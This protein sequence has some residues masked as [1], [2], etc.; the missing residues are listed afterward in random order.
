MFHYKHS[1]GIFF[2]LVLNSK[3]EVFVLEYLKAFTPLLFAQNFFFCKGWREGRSQCGINCFHMGV[4]VTKIFNMRKR[5]DEK[6][7]RYIYVLTRESFSSCFCEEHNVYT[8]QVQKGFN[9]WGAVRAVEKKRR[10]YSRQTRY[11]YCL[12][13]YSSD[14]ELPRRFQALI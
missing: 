4:W 12:I 1:P 7:R 3:Q 9:L 6:N 10:F 11:E 5:S 8:S 2:N 14:A 13:L